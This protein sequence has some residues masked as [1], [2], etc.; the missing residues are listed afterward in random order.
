MKTTRRDFISACSA[1][2]GAGMLAPNLQAQ[3][4]S[5]A[6][7]P[8]AENPEVGKVPVLYRSLIQLYYFSN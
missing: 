5:E 4:T 7:N 1:L 8:A 6:P 2:A 3:S